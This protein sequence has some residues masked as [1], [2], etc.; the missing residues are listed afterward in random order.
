MSEGDTAWL[1]V[2]T[3]LVMLMTPGLALFY[4]GMVQR[5][6]VLSTFMHCFFALGLVS[7]QWAVIG[8]SL[9]FGTPPTAASSAG[10]TISGSHGVGVEAEDA[11]RPCRTSRSCAF[12]MMFA[13]I[14]PALISGAFAERMKFSAYVAVH[15]RCGRRCLRSGRALGV[16]RR[17]LARQ[18]GRARL[19]RR[20]G[21]APRRRASRRSCARSCSASASAIRTRAHRAAQPDDD[22]H[23]RRHPVVRLVRVQRRLRARR[24][25]ASRRSRSS[26]RTWRRR[27]ARWPGASSRAVRVEQGRRCSA[28]RRGWSPGSSA[29]RRPRAS[30]RRW[31]RSRSASLAGVVCYARRLLKAR[32]GYDDALDAFG[33]HGVGG[34]TGALLTGVFARAAL[35]NGNG[36]GL[37]LLGAPGARPGG[38]RCVGRARD[39]CLAQ[40]DRLAGRSARRPGRD[41]ARRARRRAAR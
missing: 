13:V 37:H 6:N 20:H 19:R 15:A 27:R 22:R 31:R 4:G 16:G 18:A 36:G 34:A 25:T 29:S 23:R 21:R 10:S 24:R 11:R 9:A 17:R 35:N 41:R 5:K 7:V 3:A 26:T 1:L 33:V 40:G 8:Y 32:L 30:C 38:G 39:L 28:S 2:S 14:T 12:Q